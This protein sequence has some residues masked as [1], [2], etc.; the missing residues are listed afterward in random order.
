MQFAFV[1][2]IRAGIA[3]RTH[4]PK[5]PE[6]PWRPDSGQNRFLQILRFLVEHYCLLLSV[7]H[8][9]LVELPIA[10]CLLPIALLPIAL[11]GCIRRPG[12]IQ[13]GIGNK[14]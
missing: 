6:L 13:P 11:F 9:G 12:C 8:I 3:L 14:Q 10:Y 5:W 7:L 2:W 1:H 4:V